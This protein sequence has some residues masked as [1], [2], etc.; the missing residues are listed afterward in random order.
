M[1]SESVALSGRD[2]LMT[3]N[4]AMTAIQPIYINRTYN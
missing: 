3:K 2:S 1:L 4:I